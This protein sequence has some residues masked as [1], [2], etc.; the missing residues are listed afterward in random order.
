MFLGLTKK[1]FVDRVSRFQSV[2]LT[3]ERVLAAN[4]VG[5]GAVHQARSVSCSVLI[6]LGCV[7]AQFRSVLRASDVL[8]SD[9]GP[10]ELL[11]GA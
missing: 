7:T 3:L 2:K 4:S 9:K 11:S 6:M 8:Q 1:I 10:A 5:S